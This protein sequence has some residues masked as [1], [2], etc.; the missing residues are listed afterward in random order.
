MENFQQV[1]YEI[2]Q[3]FT[4]TEPDSYLIHKNEDEVKAWC[5]NIGISIELN[6]FACIK[7]V[8]MFSKYS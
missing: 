6:D 5:I 2:Y 7:A 4:W 8:T 3:I 1:Q